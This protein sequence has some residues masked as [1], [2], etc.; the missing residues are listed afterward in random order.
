MKSL[1][2]LPLL[3]CAAFAADFNVALPQIKFTPSRAPHRP[4]APRP[5]EPKKPFFLDPDARPLL[6]QERLGQEYGRMTLAA[7]LDRHRDLLTRQ[8][9]AGNWDISV[10]GDAAF[11]TYYLTFRQGQRLTIAPL[12]D[13]NRLRGDG[14]TV[15]VETG[16]RY[17]VK[18]AI[19]IF[20]PVKGS[21]I[22]LTPVD[23]T[24]GPKH[25]IKTGSLLDAVKAKSY[26]FSADGK[27]YWTLYGT[28]VDPKTN[29]LAATRSV[30]FVQFDGLNSNAWPVS[31]G[32]LP[33]DQPVRVQL[34]APYA[35]T[36]TAA[37][38]VIA[39]PR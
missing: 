33:E 21:T 8:L 22:K 36:R 13:L 24:R 28:D 17:N 37:Q 5:E 7:Q 30:L 31:E 29:T 15:T 39:Q 16:V 19:N 38:L 14:V 20:N 6:P 25:E 18:V 26:V 23:G 9:G 27:E 4:A 34:R 3:A 1:F 35:V 11:G 12:G 32:A 2:L 10:A